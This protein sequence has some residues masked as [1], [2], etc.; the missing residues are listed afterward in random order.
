MDWYQIRVAGAVCQPILTRGS[1]P[2]V[3]DR[4]VAPSRL[5]E[6]RAATYP[7]QKRGADEPGS[8]AGFPISRQGGSPKIAEPV[9]L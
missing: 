7:Y 9:T 6:R 3:T 1:L 4:D 8:K 2:P 5:A